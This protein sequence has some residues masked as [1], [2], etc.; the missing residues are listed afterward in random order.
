MEATSRRRANIRARARRRDVEEKRRGGV[1]EKRRIVGA[2]EVEVIETVLA[3]DLARLTDPPGIDE[4]TAAKEAR[5]HLDAERIAVITMIS[6]EDTG[7]NIRT[8]TETTEAAR[9]GTLLDERTEGDQIVTI[10]IPGVGGI[11]LLTSVI[12]ETEGGGSE[13]AR[14]AGIDIDHVSPV[15]IRE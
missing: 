4:K 10:T 15:Y 3:R 1:S 6:L 7:T 2:K 14:G 12:M 5:D 11:T 8:V 13:V 9:L